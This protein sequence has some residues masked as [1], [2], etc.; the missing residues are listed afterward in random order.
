[1]ENCFLPYSHLLVITF[2]QSHCLPCYIF[3]PLTIR[4]VTFLPFSI[5]SGSFGFLTYYKI[6]LVPAEVP[7]KWVRGYHT[8]LLCVS[9]LTHCLTNT[10]NCLA[11]SDSIFIKA[12]CLH[13][14]KE[15]QEI[16]HLCVQVSVQVSDCMLESENSSKLFLGLAFHCFCY[17][18]HTE[19][20]TSENPAP[21]P[22]KLKCLYSEPCPL[23]GGK[24]E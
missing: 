9:L 20:F 15:I 4:A 21:L 11:P 7:V 19:W 23:V 22:I 2:P 14:N 16:I 12:E 17:Y 10:Q 3:I 5:L 8:F 24:K 6:S 18:N 1:M 13:Y